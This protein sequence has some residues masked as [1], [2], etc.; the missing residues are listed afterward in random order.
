MVEYYRDHPLQKENLM[1]LAVK[2][3]KMNHKQLHQFL[4]CYSSC[5]TKLMKHLYICSYIILAH[6]H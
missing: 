5:A 1:T 3:E 6:Y 4:V 2:A